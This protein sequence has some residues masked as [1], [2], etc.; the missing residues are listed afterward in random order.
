MNKVLVRPG[1]SAAHGFAIAFFLPLAGARD[2][3]RPVGLEILLFAYRQF[4]RCGLAQPALRGQH[5]K[6]V[7]KAMT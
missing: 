2:L 3:K 7:C 4:A 1:A 6:D 5:V